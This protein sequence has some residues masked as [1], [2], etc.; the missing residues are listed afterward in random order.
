LPEIVVKNQH[1]VSAGILI[2]VVLWM[3]IPQSAE[4]SDE[5][6]A[7]TA[8][9]IVA[10]PE[11]VSPGENPSDYIVRAARIDQQTYGKKVRV[12]GRTQAFRHVEVRA[13]QSGRIVSEPVMRGA[14]VSEGDLLCEIAV[15]DRASNLLE[16]QSRLEQAEFE[17]SASLDLQDRGLQSDVIVAQLKAAL[18]SSKA[19]VAR[20]ELALQRTKIVAP[21][22]GVVE[23]RIVEL[24]DLLNAGTVC[25][26]VLDDSPMLL[27]GLVPE[28]DIGSLSVGA[29]VASELLTGQRIAGTVNY[30]AR[31]ADNVSRSYRIEVEVDSSFENI[32]QGIT[33]EILVDSADIQAHL[34][35]SSSLTLD[36]SGLIGVKTIGAT[37]MVEFNNVEIVGDN[38][39]AM[40]PGVWVTG[41]NGTVNLITLGQEI[42]FPGQ[43]VESNFDWSR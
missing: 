20:A 13:E 31:A 39:S 16:A 37:N 8:S 12:R 29:R 10:V 43:Q 3:V 30:L 26:S 7:S 42:V 21:F 14:R 32:R 25:A 24:G 4:E 2:A 22:D 11:G 1:V 9:T 5:S 23:T 40:N 28:Q 38:T 15:D 17:Y 41:L 33:A 18:Q 19:G 36:D 34:I 35:P 27:V 6:N